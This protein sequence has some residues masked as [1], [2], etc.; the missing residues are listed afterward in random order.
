MDFDEEPIEVITRE[1]QT[2]TFLKREK[3]D[4]FSFMHRSLMEYFL[5]RKIHAALENS[6]F[7]VLDTRR[8]DR[9]VVYFL[10][11]MGVATDLAAILTDK[12]QPKISENAL[13]ILYWSRRIN[14]GM[15]EKITDLAK[16]Q[17]ALQFPA[18]VQLQKAQL[19]E[20]ILEGAV[21]PAAQLRG[22]NF[23]KANL[24]NSDFQGSDFQQADLTQ[25]RCLKAN[26][27]DCDLTEAILPE[28]FKNY[29]ESYPEPD[30]LIANLILIRRKNWSSCFMIQRGFKRCWRG[31]CESVS[32]L[33]HT[34]E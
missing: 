7:S 22:A 34:S 23:F 19:A 26:F 20:I 8:F 2:A 31:M 15:E 1:M 5:A 4:R 18:Q 16:L 30:R 32:C 11:Q 33:N 24:N 6:D 17:Q 25:A 12:Y 9:K 14:V 21:L 3:D 28:N 29:L 13:Q 27:R 10:T